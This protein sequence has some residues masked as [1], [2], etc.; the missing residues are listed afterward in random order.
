MI[1]TILWKLLL[2]APFLILD[3]YICR[4]CLDP[5]DDPECEAFDLF[6]NEVLCVGKGEATSL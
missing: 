6:V 4:E 3:A 1:P 5:F 2:L